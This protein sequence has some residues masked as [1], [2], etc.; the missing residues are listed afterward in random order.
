M[1]AD[2]DIY[3]TVKEYADKGITKNIPLKYFTINLYLKGSV[4]ITFNCPELIQKY[5]IYV[6]KNRGWLPFDFGTK[7]YKQMNE[8][9]KKVVDSFSGEREYDK[10][11]GNRKYYLSGINTYDT[12]TLL[13]VNA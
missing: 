7:T 8:E 5:N 12:Q 13:S 9:E 11:I 4:H 10:I 1:T 2:V 3:N 6:G